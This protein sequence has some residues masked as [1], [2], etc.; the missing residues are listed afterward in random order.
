MLL[1]GPIFVFY[2]S[3][4]KVLYKYIN[5][6]KVFLKLLI[7]RVY[8]ISLVNRVFSVS[9]LRVTQRSKRLKIYLKQILNL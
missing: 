1:A 8:L 7:L 5:K 2:S 4:I 3:V 6:Y 9:L